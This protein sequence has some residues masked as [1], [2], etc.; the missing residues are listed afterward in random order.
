MHSH[1]VALQKKP[2]EIQNPC[3]RDGL[4]K[5]KPFHLEDHTGDPPPVL[6]P[7][8]N[9]LGLRVDMFWFASTP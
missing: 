4:R 8:L 1:H 6:I 3:N 7:E 5:P 9:I 2:Y